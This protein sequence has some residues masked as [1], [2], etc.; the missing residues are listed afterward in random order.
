MIFSIPA[1]QYLTDWLIH[2]CL[3]YQLDTSV[4]DDA[5]FDKLASLLRAN[6]AETEGHPHRH[7]VDE[8]LLMSASS[9]YYLKYPVIVQSIAR[10]IAAGRMDFR[11]YQDVPAATT[12]SI[13]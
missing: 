6:W 8:S 2:C 9:G 11:R 3:Y 10:E 12:R 7:L 5:E 13:P 1:H 4:I